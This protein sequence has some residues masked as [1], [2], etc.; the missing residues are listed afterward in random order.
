M[1]QEVRR[2]VKVGRVVLWGR[3]MGS[4][5]AI[6]FAEMYAYEVNALILDS[7]FRWLNKVVERIAA[8][9]V[10]LPMF[11]L[12]PAL[13]LIENRAAEEVGFN[14]FAIDYLSI[15]KKL[16]PHLPVL[17]IFSNFDSIVPAQ[18]VLDFYNAY[19]GPKDLCEIYCTHD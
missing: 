16:N 9:R 8:R 7:P 18:E 17:F 1:L 3:S 19:T 11:I 12:K 13:Y 2:H 15:F 14:L 5:C 6:M 10:K 4:L